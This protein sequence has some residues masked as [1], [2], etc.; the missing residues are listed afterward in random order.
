LPPV[1]H[2]CNTVYLEKVPATQKVRS[3]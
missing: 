1:P 3:Q 2:F